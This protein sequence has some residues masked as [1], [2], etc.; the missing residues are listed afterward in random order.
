MYFITVLLIYTLISRNSSFI[1][2][3]IILLTLALPILSQASSIRNFE[4]YEQPIQIDFENCQF[5]CGSV[6]VSEK[7]LIQFYNEI[8]KPSFESILTQLDRYQKQ[9]NL[10][11]WLYYELL[12][13]SIGIGY[14]EK[15]DKQLEL[16]SWFLLNESGYDTRLSYLNG[17]FWIYA[18]SDEEMFEVS[19]IQDF[20]KTFVNLTDT[21]LNQNEYQSQVYLLDFRPGSGGKPFQFSLTKLPSFAPKKKQVSVDFNY[22][23]ETIK[24]DFSI[25]LSLITLMKDYPFIQEQDYLKVPFSSMAKSSLIPKLKEQLEN[26]S[27][28]EKLEFLVSFTRKAFKY[29]ED[30]ASFGKSK[31][32]I[33]EEVFYHRFSDCEDRCALFYNL[34]KETI[35]LPMLIVA[36]P[37]HLTIAVST[38]TILGS[39]LKYQG[40]NYYFC[41]PTGPFNS[42]S[43]GSLPKEYQNSS[44]QILDTYK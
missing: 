24:F 40:K 17:N 23:E 41:D 11:D 32:M 2:L 25:D 30:H 33:A 1:R 13:K 7:G 19:M 26:R 15:N 29:K 5:D 36:L 34:C 10:N 9:L 31:P 42:S 3:S 27:Q 22:K 28:K 44:Y 37:D 12:Y 43:V 39:A 14:P 8:D 21:R 4:F 16:L 38:S 20:N 18:Y 35:D 6:D